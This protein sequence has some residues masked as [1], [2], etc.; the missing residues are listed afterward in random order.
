MARNL[1]CAPFPAEIIERL[2][3]WWLLSRLASSMRQCSCLTTID[4]IAKG[5]RGGGPA[6]T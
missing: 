3:G 2:C 1:E 5:D 4:S 6:W